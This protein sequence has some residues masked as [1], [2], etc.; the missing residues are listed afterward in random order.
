MI[1]RHLLD[2]AGLNADDGNGGAV[3][4]IRH[5]GLAAILNIHLRIRRSLV[6]EIIGGSWP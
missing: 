1:A 6:Q 3:T 5:F 4:L 2:A